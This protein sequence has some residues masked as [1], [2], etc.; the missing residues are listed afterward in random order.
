VTSSSVSWTSASDTLSVVNQCSTGGTSMFLQV[1][2][3][4]GFGSSVVI[5][6]L[7]N[8]STAA[9]SALGSDVTSLRIFEFD[10]MNS[11]RGALLATLTASSPSTGGGGG[12]GSDAASSSTPT[13]IFQQFGKPVSGTCETTA[14]ESLNWSG[15]SSGGWGESWSEWMNGG[16]GGAVC[17][18][19]LVYSNALSHWVVG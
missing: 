14:S 15:V 1:V 4:R 19:T 7:S 3:V 9:T 2:A 13:P 18:R 12:S 11:L 17:T 8:G 16:L 10:T 6:I 5:T